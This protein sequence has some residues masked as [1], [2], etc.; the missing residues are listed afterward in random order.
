MNNKKRQRTRIPAHLRVLHRT[1]IPMDKDE[2]WLWCG[3]VNNA[4]YG[5]IK[6]E[7][8]DDNMMTV[9]R[10]VARANGLDIEN[11]EIQHTCL[12]KHC[13]NPRH[14]VHG[15]CKSRVKRIIKKHGPNF[16]KPKEP[17]RTCEHCGKSSH[18]IW[19]SR[20]HK[21]CYPGMNKNKTKLLNRINTKQ[22]EV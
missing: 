14:L 2:C 5:L 20:M 10:V 13:V 15:D 17:Y 4:G 9:H 7:K 18:V 1:K 19:F 22:I 11:N 6:G 16:Q 21:D 3:P 12:T 8:S